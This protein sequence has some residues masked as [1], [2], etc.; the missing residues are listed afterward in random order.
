M[1]ATVAAG[2]TAAYYTSLADYYSG[3]NEPPGRWSRVGF[4]AGVTVGQQVDSAIFARLHAALDERRRTLLANDGGKLERVGGYDVTFSAPKSVSVAWGLAD[5]VLRRQIE[6]A[7]VRA[8]DAALKML[9]KNAAFCRSGK[10][11]RLREP[12]RL[13]VAAFQH[14]GARPETHADGTIFSDPNLHTHAVV[15]NLGRKA[16]GRFGALDGKGFFNWKMAAGATYHASLA[17]SLA[18]IGFGIVEIGKNGTFE[19]AGIPDALKAYFSAR[20][21]RIEEEL[22]AGDKLSAEAPAL[23]AAVARATRK[24][25]Q[26]LEGKERDHLWRERA[27]SL[28]FSHELVGQALRQPAPDLTPA[29]AER[30]AANRIDGVLRQLTE[31]QSV[32]GRRQLH[33]AL[34]ASLVGSGV[35]PEHVSS[36]ISALLSTG[37]V[38]MLDKDAWGHEVMTTP[39]ILAIE[40]EIGAIALAL[41]DGPRPTL[42]PLPEKRIAE[43]KLSSEQTAAV[44]SALD[45]QAITIIEGAPGL[46]QI[47]HAEAD[48]G[49]LRSGRLS[50]A[51][52]GH[53][54]AYRTH[55]QG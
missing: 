32:F 18:D 9:E 37:R 34:A 29:D 3:A 31:H 19:V 17:N 20:R 22:A 51:G 42:L 13:T 45:A 30:L 7:Q 25:K 49:S 44:R 4:E 11:G 21:H 40:R 27:E 10:A 6:Q 15:L 23:A 35:G 54:L 16:D 53:R 33:A 5:T 43:A 55:A 41:Q 24:E 47:N 48:Q 52:D 50:R 2:T 38:A 8:T 26:V 46:G 39:E 36:E 28:G 1:V 12:V 14:G